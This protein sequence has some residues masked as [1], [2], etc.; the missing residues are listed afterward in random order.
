ML[1][2]EAAKYEVYP[3]TPANEEELTALHKI[4]KDELRV[5]EDR[6]SVVVSSFWMQQVQHANPEG[7]AELIRKL[8]KR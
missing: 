4:I 3:V 6:T 7:Y 2:C 5:T 8:G 1:T